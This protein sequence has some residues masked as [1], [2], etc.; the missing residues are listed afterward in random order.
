MKTSIQNVNYFFF[1]DAAN[2]CHMLYAK[3]NLLV[4]GTQN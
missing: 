4:E 2:I 1:A 3:I